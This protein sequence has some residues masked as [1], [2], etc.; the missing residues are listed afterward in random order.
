MTHRLP[1][2]LAATLLM[3]TA[4]GCAAGSPKGRAGIPVEAERV[5]EGKGEL[6]YNATHG[7]EAYVL[8]DSNNKIIWSGL[9][10]DGDALAIEPAGN[11][12]RIGP[13]TVAEPNLD[14]DHRYTVYLRRD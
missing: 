14:K 8:D 7:G 6:V 2:Q 9:L 1:R 10:R 12:V 13:Q 3:L 4:V 5:A 11:R